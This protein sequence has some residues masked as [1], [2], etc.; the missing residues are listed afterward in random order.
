[1]NKSITPVIH[2]NYYVA[3]EVLKSIEITLKKRNNSV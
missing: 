1:M 2:V 3:M